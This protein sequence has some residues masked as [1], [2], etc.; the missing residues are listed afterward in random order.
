MIPKIE[1]ISVALVA[2]GAAALALFVGLRGLGAGPWLAAA[3]A[4]SIAGGGGFALARRLPADL[5]GILRTHRWWCVAWLLVALL[6]LG[7]T[8]R[9]SA[10]ML[11]PAVKQHSL[12]PDD[13]WYVAHCCLT[14]YSE[15]ARLATEG[16]TNIFTPVSYIHLTLPTNR[17]V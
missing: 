16:T 4:L 11:D 3:L 12:F 6:A 5:D 1:R 14:A 13:A 15:A 10:F 8:A 2:C 17:E 7:Q 9:M